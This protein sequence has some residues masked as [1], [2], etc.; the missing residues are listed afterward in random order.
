MFYMRQ[1]SSKTMTLTPP[2]GALTSGTK[3]RLAAPMGLPLPATTA[4][5]WRPLA[6]KNFKTKSMGAVER[7]HK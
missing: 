5:Y 6:A 1:G 4:M 7:N 2:E 3:A